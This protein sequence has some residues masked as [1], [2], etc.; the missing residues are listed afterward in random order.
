MK[1]IRNLPQRYFIFDIG[2]VSIDFK[3]LSLY[4]LPNKY[5]L[6]IANTSTPNNTKRNCFI[7]SNPSLK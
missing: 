7:T 6:T 2:V 3:V 5:A 1:N 4:S